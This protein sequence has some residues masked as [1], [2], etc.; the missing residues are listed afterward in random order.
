MSVLTAYTIPLQLP[1]VRWS[2]QAFARKIGSRFDQAGRGPESKDY[3]AQA[4]LSSGH[5][6]VIQLMPASGAQS[7]HRFEA[8]K[9]F[10]LDP[11]RM[12]DS[13]RRIT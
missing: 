3:P 4:G 2:A 10:G 5:V 9:N 8:T 13:G 7:A 12:Y 11:E 6:A 1:T